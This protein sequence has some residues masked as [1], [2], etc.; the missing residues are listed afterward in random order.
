MKTYIIKQVNSQNSI[1]DI[2]STLYERE[3]RF[4]KNKKYAVV[5]ADFYGGYSVHKNAELAIKK[6]RALGDY[7]HSI[8]DSNGGSYDIDFEGRLILKVD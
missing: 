8:F 4:P 6:S 2:A 3:I 5:L 7:T 1:H